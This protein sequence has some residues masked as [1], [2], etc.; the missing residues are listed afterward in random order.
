MIESVNVRIIVVDYPR[1]VHGD[2]SV[3]SYILRRLLVLPVTLFGMSVIIFSFLLILSPEERAGYYLKS[4]PRNEAVMEGIIK[5]YGL[6]DPIHIQYAHWLLGKTDPETGEIQGGLLRG[7]FGY[8]RF[9][10]RP[11]VELIQLRFP[12]T[13]ELAI[14]SLIPILL[15]GV[16]LGVLAAVHHNRGLDQ[17]IRVLSIIGYS[18]PGFV[19]GLLL[20]LLFY[21]ESNWFPPGRVSDWV[22]LEMLDGTYTIHTGLYTVDALWNGRWD[23]WWDAIR[24]LVLPVVTLSYISVAAFLRITRSSMLEALHQDYVTTA[25]AKGLP[26]E[27]VVYRHALPNALLPVVTYAGLIAVASLS[28]VVITETIFYFPGIGYAAAEAARQ[29][30]VVTVLG[31]TMLAGIMVTGI[32]LIVDIL[33]ALFDPRIRLK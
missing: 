23:V 15:L 24:H 26:E 11:V 19:L 6:R 30:D 17:T 28:G 32:N 8:S 27:R 25:R 1:S 21:S 9:S 33:Y 31:F 4:P 10:G 16:W 12:A 3:I 14:Y 13:L 29:F 7:N 22:R 18:L 20:L 5:R 2:L